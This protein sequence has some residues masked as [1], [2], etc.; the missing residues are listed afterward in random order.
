[1]KTKK[2]ATPEEWFKEFTPENVDVNMLC[3]ST[4]DTITDYNQSGGTENNDDDLDNGVVVTSKS[5][6]IYENNFNY[7]PFE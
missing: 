4:G 1:M 2:I 3:A 5:T 7:N 6:G